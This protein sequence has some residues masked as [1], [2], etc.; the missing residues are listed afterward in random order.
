MYWL[1]GKRES[2]GFISSMDELDLTSSGQQGD[3][4]TIET[5]YRVE[6]TQALANNTNTLAQLVLRN[7]QRGR[8]AY[9]EMTL[10]TRSQIA[11]TNNS[12]IDVRRLCQ[13]TAILEQ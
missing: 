6:I 5:T 11:C 7:Y 8:K 1:P 13:Y 3:C 9:P 10:S 12:H 4:R 2:M